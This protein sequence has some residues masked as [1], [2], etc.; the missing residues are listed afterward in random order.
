METTLIIGLVILIIVFW[1][2]AIADIMRSEF[3]NLRTK[4]FWF[5]AVLFFPVFGSIYY[6]QSKQK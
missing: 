3:K 2:R 1:F 6:F 4:T 5:L